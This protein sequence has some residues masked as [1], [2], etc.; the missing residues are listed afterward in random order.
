MDYIGIMEEN[1]ETTI[2]GVPLAG[3]PWSAQPE[4][5]QCSPPDL[6]FNSYSIMD[7]YSIMAIYRGNIDGVYLGSCRLEW[8]LLQVKLIARIPSCS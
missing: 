3:R 1:M 6:K 8:K 2:M 7:S 4:T 5:L